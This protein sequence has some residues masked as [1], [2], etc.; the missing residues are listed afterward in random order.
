MRALMYLSKLLHIFDGG[1]GWSGHEGKLENVLVER[2]NEVETEVGG[3]EHEGGYA[4]IELQGICKLL[5]RRVHS[6]EHFDVL[7]LVENFG[8]DLVVLAHSVVH[9]LNPFALEVAFSSGD[10]DF[11]RDQTE[12]EDH[13]S[14]VQVESDVCRHSDV[15]NGAEKDG[16]HHRH[17]LNLVDVVHDAAEKDSG[18]AGIKKT[19]VLNHKRIENFSTQPPFEFFNEVYVA[20]LFDEHPKVLEHFDVRLV[21][22]EGLN[23]GKAFEI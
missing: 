2:Q 10:K 9:G 1:E 12:K 22:N 15:P 20:N 13:E 23:A 4:M 18:R 6:V 3:I 16:E 17:T 8:H 7:D 14:R 5:Q 11:Q 19:H 21:Q